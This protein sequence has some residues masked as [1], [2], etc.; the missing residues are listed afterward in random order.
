MSKT[1]KSNYARK[2]DFLKSYNR[3]AERAPGAKPG[4]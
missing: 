3:K 1:K 4:A 2:R